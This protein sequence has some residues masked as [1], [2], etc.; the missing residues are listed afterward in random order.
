VPYPSVKGSRKA[1]LFLLVDDHSRLLV[2]GVWCSEENLRAGQSVLRAALL[3]RGVPDQ[4]YLDNGAAYSGAELARTCAVLGIRLIHSKPYSPQGRGK[5]E[6]LNRVIRERFLLEAEVAGID[7]LEQLNDRF[8]AWSEEYLNCRIHR[9]TGETPI[10]RFLAGGPVRTV[11]PALLTEAFRWSALRRVTRTAMVSLLGNQYQVDPALVGRRVELRYDPEDLFH[12]LGPA[13]RPV[14][15]RCRAPRDPAP[16]PPGRAA[17]HQA[18]ASPH[19]RRL[20]GHGA[21]RPP[22]EDHRLHLLPQAQP[23]GGQPMIAAPPLAPWVAHFGFY[24]DLRIMPTSALKT[25]P[26][27]YLG[28]PKRS[29]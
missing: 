4:I 28:A 7:S 13:R 20:P 29:A 17:G 16:H 8:L 14:R 10:A 2:H 21:H 9:E 22:A 3:R 5:Q 6:R 18:S 11:E 19:R 27:E 25:G 12:P 26:R 23:R 24:A 1:K 15:R